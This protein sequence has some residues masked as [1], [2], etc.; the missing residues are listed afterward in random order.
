[1]LKYFSRFILGVLVTAA[2]VVLVFGPRP[3]PPLPLGR[4]SDT[5]IHYWEKWNGAEGAA[6]QQIVD[7]FNGT[8]GKQKHIFVEMMSISDIDQKTLV[9]TAGGV[10]PD[11]AGLWDPMVVQLGSLQALVPLED[12][13]AAKGITADYYLPVFWNACHFNGHLYALVSTPASIA[14]IYNKKIF[15]DNADKLRAAGLDPDTYPKS[16]DELDRYSDVLT[17]FT[18]DSSGR[19]H[20]LRAGY[21]P[22]S[23][24][25]DWYITSIPIWFG[26]TEWDVQAQ[27][28]TLTDPG[29]IKAF[30]WIESF[31]KKFGKEAVSEFSTAQGGFNSAQNAFI[32]GKL[33]MQMQGPWMANFIHL[34]NPAM[35]HDW[36]A[37][38]FP[39]DVPGLNNVTYC[40]F[41]TLMIPRGSH[42]VAEAFEFIAFVNTQAEMEKL[43]RLHCKNCP[44]AHPS[45]D[46]LHDHPN[47]F[48]SVFQNLAASPNAHVTMQCPIAPEAGAELTA[49]VQGVLALE[50]DPAAALENAQRRLQVEYDL[51]EENLRRRMR[52]N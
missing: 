31:P 8:V 36:A 44:L 9:A 22:M 47:P 25:Y 39:S 48:I 43:C 21:L 18:T 42:H 50:I 24:D 37:A 28:F 6:M 11:V 15:H 32:A 46:F 7:D 30:Q 33:A 52:T 12:L 38:P 23:P 5:I 34:L 35:D 16:I 20:V 27:R 2:L 40:P 13:A 3:E 49:I 14:L 45:W 41:D 10:P 17:E 1:M 29:V 26:A 51:F 4:E 19:R